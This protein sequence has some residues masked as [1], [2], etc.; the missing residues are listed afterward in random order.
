MNPEARPP[1]DGYRLLLFTGFL[2]HWLGYGKGDV[3]L[4]RRIYVMRQA[5]LPRETGGILFGLV[6][7]PTKQIHLVEATSA[8]SDSIEEPCQ[9]VRGMEGADEMME[10]VQRRTAGQIRYVSE[11]HSYPPRFQF[12]PIDSLEHDPADAKGLLVKT[13]KHSQFADIDLP[14]WIAA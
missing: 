6:D 5:K 10:D 4:I 7:I 13:A 1:N 12:P 8:P 9:I 14:C 11:W 3:G 2:N